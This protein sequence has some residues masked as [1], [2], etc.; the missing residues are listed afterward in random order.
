MRYSKTY[1]KSSLLH[2][3]QN[4][5]LRA[6]HPHP[7]AAIHSLFIHICLPARLNVYIEN[8]R[9]IYDERKNP[10]AKKEGFPS[11]KYKHRAL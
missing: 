5:A 10:Q 9:K 7:I 1:R 11:N 4:G 3:S 2:F 6:S 8:S